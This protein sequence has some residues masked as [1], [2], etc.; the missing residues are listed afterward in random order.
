[1][2]KAEMREDINMKFLMIK[3]EL[4]ETK[5]EMRKMIIDHFESLKKSK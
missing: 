5:A 4:C 1:M 3:L 2:T